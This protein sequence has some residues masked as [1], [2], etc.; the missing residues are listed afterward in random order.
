MF[1][2]CYATTTPESEQGNKEY[3]RHLHYNNEAY[4]KTLNLKIKLLK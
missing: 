1:G 3:K 2:Y 4:N